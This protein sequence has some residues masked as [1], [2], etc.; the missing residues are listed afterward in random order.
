MRLRSLAGT[1]LLVIFSLGIV[2]AASAA[3]PE[4]L[5]EKGKLPV[6][7]EGSGNSGPTRIETTGGLLIQCKVLKMSGEFTSAHAGTYKL[8]IE[9]CV[10]PGGFECHTTADAKGVMLIPGEFHLVR[11]ALMP[12]KAAMLLLLSK[13]SSTCLGEFG[14]HE[15]KG[16]VVPITPINKFTT[17]YELS[18]KMVKT[19]VQEVTSYYNEAGT[20]VNNA[21]LELTATSTQ[22][23]IEVSPIKLTME[24][25]VEILA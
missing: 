2:T 6:K 21:F 11:T 13:I 23:G 7:F 9:G 8:N 22:F 19:G 12:V 24:T 4:V 25:S 20:L 17:A 5:V 16:L 14:T 15:G 10:G 1:I 3:L 18:A